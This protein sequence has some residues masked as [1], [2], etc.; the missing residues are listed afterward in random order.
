MFLLRP[1]NIAND[2]IRLRGMM[3]GDWMT[4]FECNVAAVPCDC[5]VKLEI[6]D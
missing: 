3:H 5:M 6:L 4:L 2:S 1:S